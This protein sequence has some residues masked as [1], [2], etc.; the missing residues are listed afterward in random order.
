MN[1]MKEIKNLY[2]SWRQA[3]FLF[4]I[5]FWRHLWMLCL[6]HRLERIPFQVYGLDAQAQLGPSS[7]IFLIEVSG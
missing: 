1:F 5:W 4:R 7:E 2:L 6:D 3:N